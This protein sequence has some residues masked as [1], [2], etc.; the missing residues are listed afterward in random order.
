MSS[1]AKEH[2]ETGVYV[3]TLPHYLH[4]PIDPRTGRTLLKV[5]CSDSDVI[6]RFRAQTRITALPEEPILLR[7]YRTGRDAA[8]VTETKF[9]S[10]LEAADHCRSVARSAGT[11]WFLTHTRFLDEIAKTLGLEIEVVHSEYDSWHQH[12]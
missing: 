4:Y 9:H 7:I 1:Q 12:I 11:E 2:S 10:L 5:G 8:G 3:Y 6:A